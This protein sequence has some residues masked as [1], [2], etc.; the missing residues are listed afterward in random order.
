MCMAPYYG[1]PHSGRFVWM[2]YDG[3]H[4]LVV[5]N[6]V[7]LGYLS[8]SNP[9]PRDRTSPRNC[10]AG[11]IWVTDDESSSIRGCIWCNCSHDDF[12][13]TRDKGRN[14][15]CFWARHVFHSLDMSN[16]VW[17]PSTDVSYMKGTCQVSRFWSS[18][19]VRTWHIRILWGIEPIWWIGNWDIC[20]NP[21]FPTSN[22]VH[23]FC[24]YCVWHPCSI[25]WSDMRGI[26]SDHS[27]REVTIRAH[28]CCILGFVLPFCLILCG[29]IV[30][31]RLLHPLLPYWLYLVWLYFNL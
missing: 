7:R 13:H 14:V 2:H 29:G 23:I 1:V 11:N 26:L 31:I 3:A 24:R 15:Y 19:C 27:F 28:I 22:C 12:C 16:N 21:A 18:I 4:I 8:N 20:C 5:D 30:R 10:S 6:V 17:V 9:P 25:L